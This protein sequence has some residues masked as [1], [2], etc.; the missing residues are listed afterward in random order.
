[1]QPV[2]P[3]PFRAVYASLRRFLGPCMRSMSSATRIATMFYFVLFYFV[4]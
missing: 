3:A 2:L 1:M 4:F